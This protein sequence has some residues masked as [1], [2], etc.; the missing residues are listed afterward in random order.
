MDIHHYGS[1]YTLWLHYFYAKTNTIHIV[2]AR[3]HYEG[4]WEKTPVHLFRDAEL[5]IVK[6]SSIPLYK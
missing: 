3:N 4:M 5:K 1:S 6:I 2:H